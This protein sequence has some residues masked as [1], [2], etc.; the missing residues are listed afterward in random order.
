MSTGREDGC[1]SSRG[2]NELALPPLFVLFRPS[3]AWV[4]STCTGEGQLLFFLLEY[5]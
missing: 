5:S 3:V 2:E 4:V 1:P